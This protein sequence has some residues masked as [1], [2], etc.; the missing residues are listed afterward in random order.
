MVREVVNK[1]RGNSSRLFHGHRDKIKFAR[2]VASGN[3]GDVALK[4]TSNN[5]P[6]PTALELIWG[7]ATKR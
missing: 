7:N 4:C 6:L 2:K 5:C 3:G 1:N